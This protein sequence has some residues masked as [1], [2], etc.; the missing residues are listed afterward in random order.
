MLNSDMLSTLA[1]PLLFATFAGLWIYRHRVSQRPRLLL[2]LC[3]MFAVSAYGYA[4][5]PQPALFMLLLGFMLVV[6]G[7]LL[8]HW[9]VLLPLRSGDSGRR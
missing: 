3:L 7:L 6:S 8:H 5:Q 9:E 2:S 4:Q 1:F